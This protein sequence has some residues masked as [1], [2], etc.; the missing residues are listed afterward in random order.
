MVITPKNIIYCVSPIFSQFVFPDDE[1]TLLYNSP[2][3]QCIIIIVSPIKCQLKIFSLLIILD[4]WN[5][6]LISTVVGSIL[7][8]RIANSLLGRVKNI[9]D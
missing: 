4:D 2:R 8:R 3:F 5:F 1:T 7:G 6:I 9:Q